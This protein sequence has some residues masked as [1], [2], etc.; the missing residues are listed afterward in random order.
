M[1]EAQEIDIRGTCI[2]GSQEARTQGTFTNYFVLRY[3]LIAFCGIA[4]EHSA[5]IS[6]LSDADYR[7]FLDAMWKGVRSAGNTRTKSGQV[8]RLLIDI[9]YKPGVEF[10]YGRL[11]DYIKAKAAQEKAQKEWSSFSDYKIDLDILI[12][13]FSEYKGKISQIS[14]EISPD[15]Q[16]VSPIPVE[17]KK[18]SLDE[19]KTI[20]E[21]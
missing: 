18:L 13:K 15:L 4:N 8:P 7:T 12:G 16:L 14:Y 2:L 11:A 6:R 17:W 19:S 5:K 9:E 10:Q 21:G 1:H 3:A 20:S